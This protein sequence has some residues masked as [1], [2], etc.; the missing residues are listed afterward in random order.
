MN[1]PTKNPLDDLFNIDDEMTSGVEIDE[2]QQITESEVTA[3]AAP[4]QPAADVK[5]EDDIANDKKFD[6]V[7][8][9]AFGTF[10]NQM[11]YTEI[12]EPR[13]AARN[14]EVAASYLNIALQA[15]ATKA[16]VKADRKRATA[17]IPHGNGKTVNNTIVATREEI[18]RMI[19][20]DADT[21]EV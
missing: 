6:E 11:A 10:Q 12:V 3:L 7:Y 2:Y 18:L 17:F 8:D 1:L 19:S 16:R 4:T 15:A 14:A 5:D 20:V 9:A 13:Y 21:K